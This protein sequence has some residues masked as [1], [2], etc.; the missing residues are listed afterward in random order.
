MRAARERLHDLIAHPAPV[1]ATA[2][3]LG[4]HADALTRAF[5]QVYGVSP[6]EYCHRARL[7][8]AALLLLTGAAILDVAFDAGFND[9][10]RFYAQFRRHLGTTPG[11]YARVGKRQDPA[12]DPR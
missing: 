6:K 9:L 1:R 7:F 8:E 11:V 3:S 10:S 12:A 5:G 4:I 2:A